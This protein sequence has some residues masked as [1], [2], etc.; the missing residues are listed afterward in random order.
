MSTLA[1]PEHEIAFQ[2]IADLLKEHSEKHGLTSLD[3]LAV[4]ANMVG[5]IIALQ[6]GIHVSPDRAMR[7]VA[8]NI[9][10]G[11]AQAI[12]ERKKAD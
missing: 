2:T 8:K 1:K 5:K 11:N 4:T 9:E 7:I 10:H 6:D 12:A 3:L